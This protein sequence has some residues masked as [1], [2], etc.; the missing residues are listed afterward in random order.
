ME[1]GTANSKDSPC[2][3][4]P[5]RDICEYPCEEL[6]TYLPSVDDGLLFGQKSPEQDRLRRLS[7]R[8]SQMN[9]LLD[10]EDS[11]KPRWQLIV[12]MLYRSGHDVP[13]IAEMLRV[14]IK[15]IRSVL[16]RAKQQFG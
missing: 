7:V 16:Y 10:N 5:N 15:A 1:H 8:R 14:S 12:K 9:L 2:K 11:M 3:D 6:E 4:C 13:Q